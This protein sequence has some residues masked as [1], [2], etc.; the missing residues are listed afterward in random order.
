MNQFI[1][2]DDLSKKIKDNG[3]TPLCEFL[4]ESHIPAFT[5]LHSIFLCSK[6]FMV[7]FVSSS[8]LQLINNLLQDSELRDKL[9]EK[10]DQDKTSVSIKGPVESIES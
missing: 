3:Y 4:I 1:D 8:S 10:L 6:P 9:L 7:P 2:I 5:V